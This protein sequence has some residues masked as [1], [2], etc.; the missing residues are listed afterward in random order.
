MA[1]TTSRTIAASALAGDRETGHLVRWQVVEV[2]E[3]LTGLLGP[4]MR[5]HEQM[6]AGV[7]A[8]GLESATEHQLLA[9]K[10]K[11]RRIVGLLEVDVAVPKE[12]HR[13]PDTHVVPGHW[14]G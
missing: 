11:W 7:D 8:H 5:S 12:L 6:I 4:I 13:L 9:N 3:A 10:A 1:P 2:G 14:E